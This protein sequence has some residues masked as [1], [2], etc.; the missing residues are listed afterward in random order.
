MLYLIFNIY[1]SE[2]SHRMKI[3]S[4]LHLHQQCYSGTWVHSSP[5][6]SWTNLKTILS[7]QQ[8][9]GFLK[10]LQWVGCDSTSGDRRCFCG[11]LE[12][13][14][15]IKTVLKYQDMWFTGT[16]NS[17]DAAAQEVLSVY[18]CTPTME[19]FWVISSFLRN[20]TSLL[21]SNSKP[22]SQPA[23]TQVSFY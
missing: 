15:Q 2:H 17:L 22:V 8:T 14:S 7:A 18:L 3:D 13:K 16:H 21:H 4:S 1:C 19:D 12:I 6:K 20:T 11:E 10:C 23:P 9:W 5:R